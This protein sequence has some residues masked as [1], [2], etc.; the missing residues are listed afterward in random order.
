MTSMPPTETDR[1]T[2]ST[3]KKWTTTLYNG[4]GPTSV[5]FRYILI[6]FDFFTIALF[7][8]T[9]SWPVT[10]ELLMFSRAIGLVIFIDLALRLWISNDRL[11]MLRQPYV[12]ADLIVIA[13]FLVNPF[14]AMNLSFL[15]ILRGLRLIHSYQ[16]L[17]DL[18]R[19]SRFF[20]AH[21]DA[22]IASVN[23]FVFVFFVTSA[24]FELYFV[25]D[26]NALTYIDALY[27]TVATLTTT[28]FGDITLDTPTGKMLS[29]FIMVVG[30]ALFVQ[31]ARAVFQPTKVKFDCHACGLFRHDVDAVHCK[32]CGETL[33]IHTKGVE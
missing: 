9:A 31:L 23:L 10:P 1:A 22:I 5:S 7:I 6:T 18:R 8:A 19:D 16:L 26:E 25:S 11:T 28:G 20:R 29:V 32:H 15:R 17:T 4:A 21:E 13:S 14:I 27:F 2:T 30:V 33:K 3:L 12:I 24:V